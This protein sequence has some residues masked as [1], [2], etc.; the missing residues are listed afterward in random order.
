MMNE[1]IEMEIETVE[2]AP[3]PSGPS[4][5]TVIFGLFA[6]LVAAGMAAVHLYGWRL[7]WQQFGPVS[8][9]TLGGALVLLG[10]VAALVR[11]R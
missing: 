6:L 5:P 8:L 10:V 2:H 7:D 3:R 1:D 11:R 4:W 9:V